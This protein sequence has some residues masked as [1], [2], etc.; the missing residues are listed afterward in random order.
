MASDGHIIFFDGVCGLCDR[1]VQFVLVRDRRRRFRFAALQSPFAADTLRRFG[2]DP[3]DLDTMYVLDDEGQLR[4]KGRAILFV[5]RT[6]G[7]P[8]RILTVGAILPTV[9]IDW[10]YDRVAKTRYRIFGKLEAC[11]L[12]SAEERSRFLG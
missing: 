9:V 10:F 5:L 2:K 6:L 11:R 7:W 1:L 12:P 3:A 4:R 8:W